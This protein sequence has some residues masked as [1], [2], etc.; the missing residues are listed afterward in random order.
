MFSLLV[1]IV[2]TDPNARTLEVLGCLA[3]PGI[4]ELE[5]DRAGELGEGEQELGDRREDSV[6]KQRLSAPGPK[7]LHTSDIARSASRQSATFCCGVPGPQRRPK[8]AICVGIARL[9]VA[10]SS[11]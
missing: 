4:F 9:F 6:R 8:V 1:V 10:C 11:Y 7:V 2:R 5:A 3:P